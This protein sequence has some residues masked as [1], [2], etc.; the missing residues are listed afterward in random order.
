MTSKPMMHYIGLSLILGFLHP[1]ALQGGTSAAKDDLPFPIIERFENFGSNVGIPEHKV[2]AVLKTSDGKLWI[3]TWDGLC[4]RQDDGK[5]LRYGPEHGLSHKLVLCLVEDPKTG[6]LWAGTMRG[7]NRFSGGK[8]T[9]YTQTDSGLPN[10]VVYG[11]DI[12]NDTVWAATAAGTGALDLKTGA[13]KIY[14][15]NNSIM[16]EPWCYAVKGAKDVLYIGVWGGGIVE[17][18]PIKGT[19]KEHRDPDGDFHYDLVPDDGP[20]NDITSW[21][22]WEDGI[23]WQSTY[24][25]LARYDGT[26]WRT[27]VERKTPLVSNFINFVWPHR[28][29]AWIGTDRGVSVTDG[30]CW[31]NYLVNEKR[32]GTV[33]I[34]R[35]G[36]PVETR[37]MATALPN[38]FV[39]GIFV[40]DQE[41]WFA[42]SDGLSKG[43]LAQKSRDNSVAETI[44]E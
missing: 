30:T 1:L 23:L 39:L 8:I 15:H 42:T 11:V 4:V 35:P 6:D 2:H 33:E 31:V 16:H 7:L 38:G 41:A 25:G 24:F 14:D 10:N 12:L 28:R 20:I 18:D 29:V 17:H 21:L 36:Q 34:H 40:D 44:N 27:W 22:T 5:F 32:E 3:G 19:F 9:K 26:R 43:I 13:W 37:P